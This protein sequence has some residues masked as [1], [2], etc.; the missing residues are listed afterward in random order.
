MPVS[1][2]TLH[3]AERPS[4]AAHGKPWVWLGTEQRPLLAPS[5]KGGNGVAVYTG[6]YD[7]PVTLRVPGGGHLDI[8]WSRG[9]IFGVNTPSNGTASREGLAPD[10]YVLRRS[11]A[12]C[13]FTPSTLMAPSSPSSSGHRWSLPL[14][15][16]R[17]HP[18]AAPTRM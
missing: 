9:K 16:W 7:P 12:G 5:P 15:G 18:L 1:G 13:L 2:P 3:D 11:A 4:D 10:M 6:P 14:P 8:P 17:V